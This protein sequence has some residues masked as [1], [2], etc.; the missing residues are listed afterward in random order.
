MR[1]PLIVAVA[2]LIPGLGF[3]IQSRMRE[4]VISFILVIGL[5]FMY[6]VA[7]W[8]IVYQTSCGLLAFVWIGQGFLAF[9]SARR[10]IRLQSGASQQP[11]QQMPVPSP[12]PNIPRSKRLTFRA[13]RVIEQQLQPGEHIQ[14]AVFATAP[15]NV[16]SHVLLGATAALSMKQYHV[17]LTEAELVFLQ[18]D[19]WGKPA[20][21]TRWARDQIKSACFSTGLLSDTLS[22]GLPER[23]PI[24]L[25][26]PRNQGDEASIISGAFARG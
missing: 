25:K 5:L 2:S 12:P 1:N 4:A 19:L 8:D 11:R 22:L 10:A 18:L 13:H 16:G 7:P 3:A 23:K 6:L 24:K 21:V 20:E 9:D 14:A 26:L 15:A 17:A